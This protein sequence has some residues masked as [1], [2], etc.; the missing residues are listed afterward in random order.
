MRNQY[1]L[2]QSF[3]ACAVFVNNN[4]VTY[5]IVLQEVAVEAQRGLVTKPG[6]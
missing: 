1:L 5:A 2:S 4:P 6:F 3:H